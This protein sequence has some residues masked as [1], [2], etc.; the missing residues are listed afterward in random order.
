M[1]DSLPD[2]PQLCVEELPQLEKI[3]RLTDVRVLLRGRPPFYVRS[4]FADEQT[5]GGAQENSVGV[6][7]VF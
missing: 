5:S 4:Y 7:V 2:P 1:M 3:R 6:I